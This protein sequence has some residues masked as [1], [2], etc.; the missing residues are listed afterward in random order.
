MEHVIKKLN[1]GYLASRDLFRRF[2]SSLNQ[3]QSKSKSDFFTKIK[4]C[5]RNFASFAKDSKHLMTMEFTLVSFDA[6]PVELDLQYE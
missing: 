6:N 5:N 3:L 4:K 2:M 1:Y